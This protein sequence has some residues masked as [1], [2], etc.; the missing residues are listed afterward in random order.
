M[1]E[2]VEIVKYQNCD[3]CNSSG[4]KNYYNLVSAFSKEKLVVCKKCA[5]REYYG[6]NYSKNKKYKK[7][8]KLFE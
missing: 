4:Y 2:K 5:I 1:I 7:D 8:K 6:T 3:M